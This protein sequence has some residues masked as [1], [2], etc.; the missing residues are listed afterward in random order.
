MK[1]TALDESRVANIAQGKASAIFVTSLSS[2][3]VYLHTNKVA[4]F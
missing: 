3:V 1:Y 2:R 4:V